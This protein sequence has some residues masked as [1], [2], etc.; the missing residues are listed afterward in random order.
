MMNSV[1]QRP[2]FQQR[3]VN[4]QDGTPKEGETTS[5][6][7][8]NAGPSAFSKL[9]SR[10]MNPPEGAVDRIRS[11]AYDYYFSALLPQGSSYYSP[12]EMQDARDKANFYADQAVQEYLKNFKQDRILE[13]RDEYSENP[14]FPGDVLLEEQNFQKGIIDSSLFDDSNIDKEAIKNYMFGPMAPTNQ[15]LKSLPLKERQNIINSYPDDARYYDPKRPELYFKAEGGEMKSDAVGIADGLDQ[16]AMMADASSEGIA[17]VSPE[18]YVEL[19]NQV[20]GDDVPLEGRV[21]E[22]AMTVGEKDARATPLS[23]LALVQPVFELREQEASQQGIGAAPGAD[24]MMAQAMPQPQMTMGQEGPMM[25]NQGGIVHL[26]NGPDA[27]GVYTGMNVGPFSLD[28]IKNFGLYSGPDV[29]GAYDAGQIVGSSML[30]ADAPNLIYDVGQ[31]TDPQAEYLA[32]QKWMGG[33]KKSNMPLITAA[34]LIKEGLGMAGGKDP[35][36]S[37]S[38]IGVGLIGAK[39]SEDTANQ[40][41]DQQL[42]MLAYNTAAAKN[43]ALSKAQT[44]MQTNA[45]NKKYDFYTN[46]VLEKIKQDGK[47]MEQPKVYVRLDNKGQVISTVVEDLKDPKGAQNIQKL[48]ENGYQ[49]IESVFK[50]TS[51]ELSIPSTGGD[52]GGSQQSGGA[53]SNFFENLGWKNG[54]EVVKRAN[55]TGP[56]GEKNILTTTTG[57]TVD[58]SSLPPLP[59]T[60]SQKESQ[61]GVLSI[62]PGNRDKYEAKYKEGEDLFGK[63]LE[64]RDLIL[65]NPDIVGILAEIQQKMGPA[66]LNINTIL[67]RATGVDAL[68]N[69]APGLANQLKD[70]DLQKIDRL[71]QEITDKYAAYMQRPLSVRD[72]VAKILEQYR[73][74]LKIEGFTDPAIALNALDDV[75]GAVAVQQDDYR[76]ALGK[77]N[78]PSFVE[79]IDSP[80]TIARKYGVDLFDSRVVQAAEA[81]KEYP[82]KKMEI[83]SYLEEDLKGE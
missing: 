35:L 83:L 47:G 70:P 9:F 3:V 71:Q 42:K 43:A 38:N 61:T 53:I 76:L 1:L 19:M 15:Y 36:E 34:T 66:A 39:V 16:E 64:A 27:K 77:Q 17:K 59:P 55:G 41:F 82:D 68:E 10:F 5:I 12:K 51:F 13:Y 45:I 24:Q 50:S 72:R 57:T 49:P 28:Q 8:Y 2:M 46:T 30:M 44:D 63:L 60:I 80:T 21:E 81:I 48:L 4:R 7:T 31:K 23:V 32:L 20:R 37:L 75:L 11:D 69:L 6:P 22:L 78:L 65:N 79:R 29:K 58:L 33:P 56:E 74:K 54:G 25:M 14:G 26:A 52:T 67:E 73:N 62:S 18:Q 40:N